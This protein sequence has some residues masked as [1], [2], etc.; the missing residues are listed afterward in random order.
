MSAATRSSARRAASV[1]P[2][3]PASPAPASRKAQKGKGTKRAREQGQQQE[4][5]GDNDAGGASS[6]LQ[7]PATASDTAVALRLATEHAALL[8]QLA[9]TQALV[10]QLTAAAAGAAAASSGQ[11]NQSAPS[12]LAGST[13]NRAPA[14]RDAMKERYAGEG[15]LKLDAWIRSVTRMLAFYEGMTDKTAVA[16]LATGLDGAAGD[17]FD[18]YVSSFL[19]PPASPSALFDG[20]RRRFQ[21]VNSAETARRDLDVLRQAKGTSVNDYTTRFRQLITHLPA[22]SMETRKFQYR[23]GLLAYIEERISQAEPQPATLDA[24]IALAARIE[25]RSASNGRAA[26]DQVAGAETDRE[27]GGLISSSDQLNALLERTAAMAAEAA[28]NRQYDSRRNRGA[29]K[30]S[31]DQ[32]LWKLVGLT[33]EEGARRRAGNLC[34]YCSGTG[35]IYRDCPDR[36]AKKP[37][38][39]N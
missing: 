4:L 28:V 19:Q 31:K 24:V 30:G 3:A 39:L 33:K 36:A 13:L 25:G 35:H 37:A 32:P 29:N 38:R 7:V 14:P 2:A 15:G 17:W 20:L 16:W 11:A 10:R 26:N 9:D 34:M 23:R 18:E 27:P 8:K 6:A 21:P 12:S 5:S 22:D 1:A